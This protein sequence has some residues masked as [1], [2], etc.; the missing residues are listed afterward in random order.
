MGIY[1]WWYCMKKILLILGHPNSDSFCGA[2]AESYYAW[3]KHAGHEV[4]FLKLW[5]EQFDPILR[6]G[7]NDRDKEEP[8][9]KEYRDIMK[10]AD[11]YVFVYPTWWYNVPA[12]LKG[13]FDRVL[14]S[15][16]AFKYTSRLRRNMLLK[17]SS[18]RLIST[19]GGPG[20]FYQFLSHFANKT[21][22][23]TLWFCGV[24]P[25]RVQN[26]WWL[27]SRKQSFHERE[28]MLE[29]VKKMGSQ[30]M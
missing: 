14:T 30:A 27:A 2:L 29:K 11:H 5:E 25:V 28:K 1:L 6:P 18:A 24:R 21:V 15:G 8:I 20:R 12:L 7:I 10:W 3:A 4:R 22:K 19:T 17:G 13:R 23:W 16:F 26:F 9:W